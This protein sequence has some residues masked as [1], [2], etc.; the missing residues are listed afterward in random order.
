M[1][2]ISHNVSSLTLEILLSWENV[3][4]TEKKYWVEVNEAES[5]V[6]L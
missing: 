2:R 6:E 1:L 5:R 3:A 4:I